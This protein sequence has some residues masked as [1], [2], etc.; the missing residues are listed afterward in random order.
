MG[1]DW[2]A[3]VDPDIVQGLALGFVDCHSKGKTEGK[4]QAGEGEME[5]LTGRQLAVVDQALLS[6]KVTTTNAD[7][8]TAMVVWVTIKWVPLQK[9]WTGSRFR[10]KI[11][12]AS[13]R[14]SNHARGRLAAF[15][16]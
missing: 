12:G 11:T 3:Q 7:L 5:A 15:R 10:S 13:R 4:L 1:K 14:R 6:L 2:P 8:E 9:S 16:L